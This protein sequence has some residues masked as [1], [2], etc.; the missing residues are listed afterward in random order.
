MMPRVLRIRPSALTVL[1]DNERVIDRGVT[2]WTVK[3]PG[4]V[5]EPVF[6]QRDMRQGGRKRG[7]QAP[8]ADSKAG[9]TRRM[10]AVPN[11]RRPTVLR[12]MVP[13][14]LPR[15]RMVNHAPEEPH[16]RRRR[17]G[18]NP[19]CRK[20]PDCSGQGAGCRGRWFAA[21]PCCLPARGLPGAVSN[22]KSLLLQRERQ[23]ETAGIFPAGATLFLPEG[24]PQVVVFAN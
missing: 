11:R 17:P 14:F 9:P 24:A 23:R 4:I 16:R 10:E 1:P 2:L 19:S 15:S 5:S 22:R 6:L 13:L 12:K 3:K 18:G 20:N 7:T 8:I 21:M